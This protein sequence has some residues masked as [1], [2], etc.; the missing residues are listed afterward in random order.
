MGQFDFSLASLDPRNLSE[1]VVRSRAVIGALGPFRPRLA[2]LFVATLAAVT[3]AAAGGA[4][5]PSGSPGSSGPAS[6]G[7]DRAVLDLY[8]LESQLARARAQLADA[9]AQ[10]DALAARQRRTRDQL[11][12]AEATLAR[13]CGAA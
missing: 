7:P 9:T 1:A 8:A 10:A 6:A 2:A 5:P 4:A 13:A 11:R 12:F 3:L